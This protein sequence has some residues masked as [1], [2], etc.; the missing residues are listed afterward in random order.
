VVVNY[1]VIKYDSEILEAFVFLIILETREKMNEDATNP[2][3]IKV[4]NSSDL[5]R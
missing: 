3:L 5:T 1:G 4:L 2:S